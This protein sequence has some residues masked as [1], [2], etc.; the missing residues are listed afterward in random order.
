[1]AKPSTGSRARVAYGTR[2]ADTERRISVQ[3]DR[4]FFREGI[5]RPTGLKS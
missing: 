1:M 3:Y 2:A 5:L 4:P